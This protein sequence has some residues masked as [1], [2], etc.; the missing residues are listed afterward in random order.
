MIS[1]RAPD[2]AFKQRLE[3]HAKTAGVSVQQYL[4]L[5]V[6]QAMERGTTERYQE[7]LKA[8][9]VENAMLSAKHR[10]EETI[11]D[12][13]APKDKP[14]FDKENETYD[15]YKARHHAWISSRGYGG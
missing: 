8:S 10:M 6:G 13:A 14:V 4:R 11:R 5:I 3:K 1:F 7:R 2:P 9:S 15:E 12:E